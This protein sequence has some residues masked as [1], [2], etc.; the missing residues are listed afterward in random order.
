[1][2]SDQHIDLQWRD[3]DV[4]VSTQFD[5]PYFSLEDGLAETRHVFLVGNHLPEQFCPGFWI[6]ALEFGSGLNLLASLH[7]WRESGQTGVLHYTSF[8]AFPMP[9]DAMIR[10]QA[11]FEVL[12]AMAREFALFWRR[13]LLDIDLSDLRFRLVIGDARQIVAGWS[14][15][16][17]VWFLD[18]FS[19]EKNPEMWQDNLLVAVVKNS[20]RQATLTTYTAAGFVRRGLAVAGFTVARMLGFGRKRHIINA[21]RAALS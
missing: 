5:D 1:M 4:P 3:G 15:A 14:G 20:A 13:G 7:L 9:P 8:E 17:D 21:F 12:A 10:A 16:A 11:G 18:G 2:H 19:R 6:A